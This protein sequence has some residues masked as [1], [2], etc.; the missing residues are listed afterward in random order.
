MQASFFIHNR[1]NLARKLDDGLFVLG[2]YSKMQRTSYEAFDFKQESNFWYLSGISEPDWLLIHDGK[3]NK[4]WLVRPKENPHLAVFDGELSDASA[5]DR[6]GVDEVISMSQMKL[7]LK[8]LVLQH[9]KVYTVFPPKGL[10]RLELT[11]NPA[12]SRMRRMLKT[13]SESVIDCRKD[14][15]ELRAIKQPV[16]LAQI[17]HAITITGQAFEYVAQNINDYKNEYSIE[18]DMSYMFRNHNNAT[19]AYSPIVASDVHACTL[20]YNKNSAKLSKNNL[21]LIDVGASIN[22]YNADITRTFAYGQPTSRMVDV[23]RAVSDA[24]SEVIAMLRPNLS[25]QDIQQQVEKI[26]YKKLQIIGLDKGS[27]RAA[28]H[29]YFPHAIGHGLG[30]DVHEPLA[31]NSLAEGMVLTIEPGIYIQKEGIG[32]RI[33]DNILI[34]KDGHKNL[35]EHIRKDLVY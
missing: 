5:I 25:L 20:H 14:L 34:T 7:L 17:Q 32:V 10:T 8:K 31:Y 27:K 19:H 26:M 33:E 1:Q 11:P 35:S 23:F 22:G 12:P 9:K 6:S 2:A 18:A 16:E 3:S 21:V 30:I 24:Q 28:L 29:E 15:A 13:Y 4:S